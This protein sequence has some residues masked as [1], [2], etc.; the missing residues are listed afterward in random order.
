[1][2]KEQ[3]FEF[4]SFPDFNVK[5]PDL[6]GRLLVFYK[7]LKEPRLNFAKFSLKSYYRSACLNADNK[8]NIIKI[9]I[10]YDEPDTQIPL[11][12]NKSLF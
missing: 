12:K 9:V 1:M 8:N 5:M 7:G 4:N 10:R 11:S 2:E 3:I 6:P